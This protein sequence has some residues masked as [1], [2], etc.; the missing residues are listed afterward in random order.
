MAQPTHSDLLAA[1]TQ[2]NTRLTE[3]N[4]TVKRHDTAIELLKASETRQTSDLDEVCDQVQD[5]QLS[6]AKSAGIG[7]LFG[8]VIAGLP[9]IVTAVK[10]WLTKP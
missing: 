4:G 2:V 6:Q 8:A 5:L 1:I 3:M 9:Q 7:A 10:L